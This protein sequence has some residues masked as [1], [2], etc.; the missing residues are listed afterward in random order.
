MY[1]MF[2]LIIS[3]PIEIQ[4]IEIREIQFGILIG[5]PMCA[6]FNRIEK[7]LQSLQFFK[8]KNY[9]HFMAIGR[10]SDFFLAIASHP[11]IRL[12][13]NFLLRQF[14]V[15]AIYLPTFSKIEE[16]LQSPSFFKV[17]FINFIVLQLGARFILFTLYQPNHLS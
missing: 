15:S 12:S 14:F 2:D 17:Y 16:K 8:V 6:K 9:V 1:A 4:A 7:K 5:Y 11:L 13:P 10:K 3:A